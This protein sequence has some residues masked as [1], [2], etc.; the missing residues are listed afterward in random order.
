MRGLKVLVC[1][2]AWSVSGMAAAADRP[3]VVEL[4]TSEGCSSC[5]PADAVLSE[6]ADR[7]DVLALSFHVD[8]WNRLGW[9]DPFSASWATERQSAYAAA[10]GTRRVYTPQMMIDG[11]F[12]VVGSSRAEILDAIE[13]ARADGAVPLGLVPAGDRLRVTIGT[14][15]EGATLWLLGYDTMHE[16][17]VRRG[18][19]A[20]RMLA[21]RNIVRSLTPIAPATG[22]VDRPAG[23]HA[24]VLLQAADGTILGAAR[25]AA[26]NT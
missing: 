17:E 12:D 5:P 3:V 18:E 6:L 24:A 14:V 8:Y 19:N 13:E 26:G 7:P 9:V 21:H 25:E 1:A 20:G 16:T 11:R 2:F 23:D 4:F 22:A 10:R 15:P